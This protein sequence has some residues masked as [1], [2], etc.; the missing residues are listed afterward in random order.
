MSDI[1]ITE[2]N[3]T[4]HIETPYYS[5]FVKQ[6][7]AAGAK[8]NATKKTWDTDARNIETVREILRKIYG[9][10]DRPTELVSIRV[11]TVRAWEEYLGPIEMFGRV[12]ASAH[13][14]DGGAKVGE[15][16]CFE[17]KKPTSGGSM[18]NWQTIIPDGAVF[19]VHD[20]P[21]A[22]ALK[23]Y[24]GLTVEIIESAPKLDV[25]ALTEEKQRLLTRI[26]E[27]DALLAQA[28]GDFRG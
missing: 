5:P 12:I 6:I 14:R 20:V 8:W 25:P 17:K 26:A 13:N 2:T 3:G 21:K 28:D 27:I 19:V 9:R 18:K 22:L 16:V 24:D 7:K 4:I 11:T 15:G 1:K 10:D 23:K